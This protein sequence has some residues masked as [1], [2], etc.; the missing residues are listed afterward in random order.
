M[1]ALPGGVNDY[2]IP[3]KGHDSSAETHGYFGYLLPKGLS[4]LG[5]AGKNLDR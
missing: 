2:T 4:I 3:D 1:P 5:I